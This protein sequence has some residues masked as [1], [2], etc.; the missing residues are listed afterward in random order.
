MSPDL[1]YSILIGWLG[2]GVAGH[3]RRAANGD[4]KG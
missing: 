4:G 2:N 3:G 1:R